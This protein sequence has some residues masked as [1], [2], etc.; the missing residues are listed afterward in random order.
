VEVEYISGEPAQMTVGDLVKVLMHCH[1]DQA[2]ALAISSVAGNVTLV[3]EELMVV[4]MPDDTVVI[5]GEEPTETLADETEAFL[6]DLGE[7]DE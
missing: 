7:K 6:R 4:V 3:T 2:V 1:P 5:G